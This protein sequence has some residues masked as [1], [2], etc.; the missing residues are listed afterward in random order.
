MF[1]NLLIFMVV[2]FDISRF[3]IAIFSIIF[4][5]HLFIYIE[6]INYKYSFI[7][8]H[9]WKYL[10]NAKYLFLLSSIYEFFY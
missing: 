1:T 7:I 9:I 10:I 4:P 5:S 3:F 2:F 6:I 8:M